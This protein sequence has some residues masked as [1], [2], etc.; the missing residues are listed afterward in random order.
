MGVTVVS[1]SNTVVVCCSLE[2]LC[3]SSVPRKARSRSTRYTPDQAR[4]RLSE[5]RLHLCKLPLT[6]QDIYHGDC[7]M[8]NAMYINMTSCALITNS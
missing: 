3:V 7:L 1:S 2:S 5:G 4:V 8:L 6:V